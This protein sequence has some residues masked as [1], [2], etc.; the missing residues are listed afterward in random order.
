MKAYLLERSTRAGPP[1]AGSCHHL[2]VS[3]LPDPLQPPQAGPSG[4]P[5]LL[6]PPVPGPSRLTPAR[7]SR[8][9]PPVAHSNP[10]QPSQ[11]RRSEYPPNP[12]Q[13]QSLRRPQQPPAR[14]P[15]HPSQPS[16]S[17]HSKRS[18]SSAF[19]DDENFDYDESDYEPSDYDV[20]P[21]PGRTELNH[22]SRR[23]SKRPRTSYQ[24]PSRSSPKASGSGSPQYS[25]GSSEAEQSQVYEMLSHPGHMS[26]ESDEHEGDALD[27]DGGDPEVR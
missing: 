2:P 3:S 8:Q 9:R 24:T 18:H 1:G 26:G 17:I 13:P 27:L 6:A 5:P 7:P 21:R 23:S 15:P 12:H 16:Q 4:L 25:S 14:T 19:S 20:A 11:G 22:T 10:P